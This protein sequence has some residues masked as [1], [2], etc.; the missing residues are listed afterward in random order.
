MCNGGTVLQTYLRNMK[1]ILT[2]IVGLSLLPM[3]SAQMLTVSSTPVSQLALEI[4][5]NPNIWFDGLEERSIFGVF[6]QYDLT[7]VPSSPLGNIDVPL[8]LTFESPT[9]G[10]IDFFDSSGFNLFG[11][12]NDG[13]F[14]DSLTIDF[15]GGNAGDRN[16]LFFREDFAPT[17]YTVFGGYSPIKGVGNLESVKIANNNLD[18]FVDFTMWNVDATKNID[19]QWNNTDHFR[20][21]FGFQDVGDS[22]GTAYMLMFIDDRGTS[23][24]KLWDFN[25][26]VFLLTFEVSP[27]PEP[28][29]IALLSVIGLIG[30]VAARRRLKQKVA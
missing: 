10:A 30:I 22:F 14:F 7:G 11:F 28:S 13:V 26:G 27:V 20:T 29:T 2:T 19:A 9:F 24:L 25:D 15:I 8:F 17:N 1:N 16:S 12:S 3:L 5:S 4:R 23:D 21:Y 6:D 18:S